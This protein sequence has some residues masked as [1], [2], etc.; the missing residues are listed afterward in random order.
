MS[1]TKEAPKDIDWDGIYRL[2]VH[3]VSVDGAL[4]KGMN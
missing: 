3:G 2:S 4:M 1:V